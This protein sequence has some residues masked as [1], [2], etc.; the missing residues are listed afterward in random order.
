MR[1]LFH[2]LEE[3]DERPERLDFSL[4]VIAYLGSLLILMI[5]ISVLQAHDLPA[6]QGLTLIVAYGPASA[7]L[8]LAG[9]GRYSGR[10]QLLAV[11]A[12]AGFPLPAPAATDTLHI[13]QLANP[14][15]EQLEGYRMKRGDYP[16]TLEQ[17]GID[18]PPI[19]GVTWHYRQLSRE[20]FELKYIRT[21]DPALSR[22]WCRESQTWK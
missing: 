9:L 20:E 3:A 22:S 4:E 2:L 18:A 6:W 10:A 1:F 8:W 11:V 15:I 16:E 5:C 7:L 12:V 14:M 19:N 21:A 13:H 17:A